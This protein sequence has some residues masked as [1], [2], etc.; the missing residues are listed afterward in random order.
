MVVVVVMIPVL[1]E[2]FACVSSMYLHSS[3]CLRLIKLKFR[4]T[5]ASPKNVTF[6]L[7][8]PR[9]ALK[10]WFVV[11]QRRANQCRHGSYADVGLLPIACWAEPS[12]SIQ[13][14]QKPTTSRNA[15]WLTVKHDPN[16]AP[17]QNEGR[18]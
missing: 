5:S 1:V 2:S 12:A 18:R 11:V 8:F 17:V 7:Y 9:L 16:T 15:Q 6:S 4:G 10:A 3:I 14:Q 13:R